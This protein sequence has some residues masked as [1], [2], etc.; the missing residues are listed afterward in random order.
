MSEAIQKE[1]E[2]DADIFDAM[3]SGT[4]E[5]EIEVS[6]EEDEHQEDTDIEDIEEEEEELDEGSDGDLDEDLEDDDVDD[7]EDALVDTDDLDVEDEDLDDVEIEEDSDAEEDLIETDD[8]DETE[9]SAETKEESDGEPTDTD[10]VDYKAFYD[11]VVNTEFTVNGKKVKGFADPKKI[12]Q[13]QQMAGGFSE[14]M[15]G[16]KQYR[17]YMAPLKERGMLDDPAKFDLAMNLVDGD[18]EAIK[19]HLNSL[20][21]DPLDLDM[22]E[23]KYERKVS[24][25]SESSMAIE[26]ALD[27]ARA[28]GVEDT[29]RDVIG[30][31]WDPESFEEFSKNPAVRNDLINHISTGAYSQVEDKMNELSRLDYSGAYGT[32]STVDKYRAAVRAIQSEVKTPAPVVTPKAPVTPAVDDSAEKAKAAKDAILKARKDAKYKAKAKKELAARNK[33]R[34][35][36]ASVSGKKRG[37]TKQT[38]KFDPMALEGDELQAHLDFLASGGR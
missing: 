4:F 37:K 22:E 13:S 35:L 9:D 10:T 18:V 32:M 34:E 17:P 30:N 2:F 25:A 28:A 12:I 8:V 29:L 24:T 11:A 14:K 38:A 16:F 1:A 33:Q 15:A 27:Q 21:I 7:G 31:K 19:A 23:V 5:P 36:A 6:V 20:K 26:D 3:V